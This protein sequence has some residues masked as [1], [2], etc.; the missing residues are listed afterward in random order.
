MS[1]S[2][3]FH[4]IVLSSLISCSKNNDVTI[5]PDCDKGSLIIFE[6]PIAFEM[7]RS[8]NAIKDTCFYWDLVGAFVIKLEIEN[9]NGNK[10]LGSINFK[11]PFIVN[12]NI[13][14][15]IPSSGDYEIEMPFKDPSKIV[16]NGKASMIVDGNQ[17]INGK[18]SYSTCDGNGTV[19][20]KNIDF[21]SSI[22]DT[23]YSLSGQMICKK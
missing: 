19:N 20:F 9:P 5:I 15:N 14:E 12:V 18:I 2:N 8:T 22:G 11:N 17:A 6:R 1:R 3:L 16:S 7:N 23:I 10:P 13:G 4:F 21:V